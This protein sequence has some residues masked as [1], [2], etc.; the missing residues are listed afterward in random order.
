MDFIELF[1]LFCHDLQKSLKGGGG[2]DLEMAQMS[3][4]RKCEG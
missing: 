2:Y 4:A 1:S 3:L